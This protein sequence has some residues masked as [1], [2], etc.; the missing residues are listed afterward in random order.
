M[1]KRK[2]NEMTGIV[3][4]FNTI[5]SRSDFISKYTNQFKDHRKMYDV[6]GYKNRLRIEDYLAVYLRQ[7]I[8]QRIVEAYPQATWK[9]M[10]IVTDTPLED[11]TSEFD[12]EYDA[13]CKRL[14]LYHYLY[15]LDV[16]QAIGQ[17]GVLFIGV[18]GEDQFN[19]EAPLE[20]VS[21][22][23]DIL[24]LRPFSQ[25]SATIS[26]FNTNRLSPRFN[27]PEIYQLETGGDSGSDRGSSMPQNTF[28]VHHSRIIH[29]AENLL[30]NEVYGIPIL[31]KCY[32]RLN[33]LE[34]VVGGSAETFWQNAR[35][36]LNFNLD[37]E[38]SLSPQ[39]EQNIK[40]T[41]QDYMHQLSRTIYS[42]GADVKLLNMPVA[43]PSNHVSVILDLIAG[44]TGIPKRIL[45]GSERGELSSSQDENNFINRVEERQQNF[46]EPV[47]LRKVVDRFIALGA[48]PDPKGYDVIWKTNDIISDKEKSEIARNKA[49]AISSYANTIGVPSEMIVTPKQFV[50]D[51]LGEEY[52]EEEID[53]LS[54]EETDE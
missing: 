3:Q 40:K 21:G 16:L 4:A 24:F 26:K 25:E 14:N 44:S 35:G 50:E 49:Q 39:D 15:R 36:G 1:F 34:K 37:K 5:L 6:L 32:N 41:M 33:D 23:E 22:P 10:P 46:A 20:S 29:C 19:L 11:D 42:R 38:T 47:I 53:G 17:Y 45:I 13:L 31:E 52:R 48:L 54:I 7:D 12:M 43:D 27:M 2:N 18:A 30:E 28:N 8:A 9:N 51:I